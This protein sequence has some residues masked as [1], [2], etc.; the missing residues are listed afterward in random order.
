ML[1][2]SFDFFVFFGIVTSLYFLLSPRHRPLMLLIASCYFY[3]AFVPIYILIL[4]T[5]IV[6]DYFAGIW[7]ERSEGKK[8]KFYLIISIISTC[9]VLFVFKYANF[10]VLNFN[11]V[12][13]WI[14]PSYQIENLHIFLP[15]GLSFHTFQSLSYVIEVYRRKQKA[16]YNFKIYALYV[17]FYP[18]LVAGPIE[19]PQ[20]LFHQFYE[21]HSFD[22]HRI[23]QGFRLMLWGFFQKI[24]IADTLALYVNQVYGD[25]AQYGTIAILIATYFFA[26]QIYC[27]FAGYSSIAIGTALVMG[28]RLMDNFRSPYFSK[29][30]SEFWKR[31]HISLSTWFKDYLYIPLGGNRTASRWRWYYNLL[32]VFV[33]SGFWHGANWT[34]VVWGG[35][36]GFYLIMG[37]VTQKFRKKWAKR[38]GFT[39]FLWIDKILNTLFTFHLVL[40]AWI[41]FRAQDVSTA[42]YILDKIVIHPDFSDTNWVIQSLSKNQMIMVL[43]A[44]ASMI[45]V[46]FIGRTSS[47]R[48]AFHVKKPAVRWSFY[49][50]LILA[51]LFLGQHTADIDFLYFQF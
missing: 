47:L 9:L 13:S 33:I 11:V 23:I 10:F 42:F 4:F 34:Y 2:N 27:D 1:F 37:I 51:I 20:N 48:D 7:I 16:E 14:H 38:L 40:L 45:A 43:L 32:I 12:S 49:A 35:L 15:I 21:N 41:F 18:Q 28:F 3:M 8:R 26:I 50:L 39:K 6:I 44:I 24:V 36:H 22:Y 25:V 19:R 46:E 31:W 29:S 5:T 30:I 17:M